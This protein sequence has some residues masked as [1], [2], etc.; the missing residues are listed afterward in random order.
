MTEMLYQELID[1]EVEN[2]IGAG[3]YE[4]TDGHTT[5]QSTKPQG[6]NPQEAYAAEINTQ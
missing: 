5:Q 4:R 2:M 6:A 1:A 3:K